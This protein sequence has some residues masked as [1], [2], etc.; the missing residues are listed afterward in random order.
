MLCEFTRAG[1][2]TYQKFADLLTLSPVLICIGDKCRGMT[3]REVYVYTFCYTVNHVRT[4]IV[5]LSQQSDYDICLLCLLYVYAPVV[6]LALFLSMTTDS[7]LFI[8]SEISAISCLQKLFFFLFFF[9]FFSSLVLVPN[10][11]L[12]SSSRPDDATLLTL[13]IQ[14]SEASSRRNEALTARME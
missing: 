5:S 13:L 9:F 14:M 4:W 12:S 6:L 8:S 2:F 10:M 1:I 11:N 3:L 7:S